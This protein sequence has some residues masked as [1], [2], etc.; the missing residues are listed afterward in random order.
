[1]IEI[2]IAGGVL[3][4]AAWIFETYE[5]VKKH[6]SLVDL[7]FA[8]IYIISTFLLTVYAYQNNDIVFFSVNILLIILVLFEIAYTIYK[9]KLK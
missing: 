4:L 3:L 7:K 8:F 9:T 6:K 1:M 5:S 2:G